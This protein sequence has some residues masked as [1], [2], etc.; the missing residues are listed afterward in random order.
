MQV[1]PQIPKAFQLTPIKVKAPLLNDQAQRLVANLT[2]NDPEIHV[3]QRKPGP[4]ATAEASD[5][6]AG[7]AGLFQKLQEDSGENLPYQWMDGCVETGEGIYKVL[8]RPDRWDSLPDPEEEEAPAAYLDRVDAYKVTAKLPIAMRVVDRRTYYPHR[9]ED[10]LARVLEITTRPIYKLREDFG[11]TALALGDIGL[12]MSESVWSSQTGRGKSATLIEY[13]DRK[14][15]VYLLTPSLKDSTYGSQD[16]P[17]RVLRVIEHNY[18]RPPYFTGYGEETSNSDPNFKGLS[19]LFPIMN[20][21][22]FLDVLLTSFAN[23]AFLQGF[24]TLTKERGEHDFEETDIDGADSEATNEDI[25]V[26]SILEGPAGTKWGVL[27]FSNSGR[28]LTA[29]LSQVQNMTQSAM[30]PAIMQGIPPGSRTA[31]YA[32]QELAQGAKAKYQNIVK[33]AEKA[34]AEALNFC[35]WLIE[36]RVKQ[37]VFVPTTKTDAKTGRTYKTFMKLGPD[38]IKGYYAVQVKI[39]PRNPADRQMEGTF[40]ANMHTAGLMPRRVAIEEGLGYERPDEW[41][42][43]MYV[44]EELQQPDVREFIRKQAMRDAGLGP[45]MADMQAAQD[46][47]AMQAQATQR[48]LGQGAN[49]NAAGVQQVGSPSVTAPTSPGME[50]PG[51]AGLNTG[52]AM[53]QANATPMGPRQYSRPSGRPG[54]RGGLQPARPGIAGFKN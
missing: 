4:V 46:V 38:Q 16:S 7:L 19:A 8:W 53:A 9:D 25:S 35:L 54:G 37:D 22:P 31:G 50:V 48:M 47:L 51:M 15:A 3:P 2:L 28:A 17:G 21:A 41:I 29:M 12:P 23:L 10:G 52:P 5:L 40:S 49:G 20:L 34:L 27:D 39:R 44:E 36:H 30:L 18:G 32:I 6:E 45:M 24:P 11:D 42:T 33:N 1:D 26:G 14:Y 13:W 43:E